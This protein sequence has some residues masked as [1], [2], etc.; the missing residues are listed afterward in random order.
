MVEARERLRHLGSYVIVR[1]LGAGGMGT[2]WYAEHRLL[3]RPAALK[4]ISPKVL[5][6][7][8]ANH[9]QVRL[10]FERE[11]KATASLSSCNTITIFDYGVAADGSFYYAMELLDGLDL[12]QLVTAFGP[13]PPTRVIHILIQAC[14]SLG[15]AHL[16]GLVHRD[17]KPANIYLCRM[18]LDVDVVKILDFGLVSERTSAAPLTAVGMV[19]GTPAYMA[20]EQAQGKPLDGRADLYA[21]GCVAYWLLTAKPVFAVKDSVGLMLAHIHAPPPPLAVAAN[22][23]IPKALSDLIASLLAKNPAHRPP[24][25]LAVI[26]ALRAIPEEAGTAW[27]P[28]RAQQWWQKHHREPPPAAVP[29]G[30]TTRSCL[31]SAA[32]AEGEAVV[33]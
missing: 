28:S 2:V 24:D 25:A 10:R 30:S 29:A 23:V 32:G 11:A 31:A 15:E 9:D 19:H 20:P 5:G 3:A 33:G 14:L 16:H 17:V 21:L 6:P 13:Q 22:H 1:Q 26:A 4:L 7:D 12:Q 8:P 18:G 27:T